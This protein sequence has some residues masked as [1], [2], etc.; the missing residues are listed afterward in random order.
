ME[1][2]R[3]LSGVV[4]FFLPRCDLGTQLSTRPVQQVCSVP[5]HTEPSQHS[6]NYSQ[7][8]KHAPC[9]SK[10]RSCSNPNLLHVPCLISISTDTF[11]RKDTFSM[12]LSSIFR[13]RRECFLLR[14]SSCS[15]LSSTA[16]V[17][18][19]Y[20]IYRCIHKWSTF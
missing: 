12:K 2:R 7:Y 11:H 10:S 9:W 20:H 5:L 3:R 8:P 14:S 17:I 19:I 4:G 15:L 1:I 16:L 18:C 13:T 6:R